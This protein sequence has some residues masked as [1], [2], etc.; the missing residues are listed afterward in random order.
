VL[1]FDWSRSTMA[2]EADIF[3]SSVGRIWRSHG[4]KPHRVAS[5]KVSNDPLFADKLEAIVGLLG[6]IST[7][8]STRWS[9]THQRA[10]SFALRFLPPP[11]GASPRFCSP[12]FSSRSLKRG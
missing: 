9:R 2:R 5:F 10:E 3:E 11:F 6:F 1:I 12:L 4:L 8:Q 7:R